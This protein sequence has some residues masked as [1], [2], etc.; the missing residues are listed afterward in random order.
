MSILGIAALIA[1]VVMLC[2]VPQIR[3][4]LPFDYWIS[5]RNQKL[6]DQLITRAESALL[7]GKNA[8]AKAAFE[9]AALLGKENALLMSEAYFGLCRICQRDG[10]LNGAVQ[11]IDKALHYAPK[12]REYKRNFEGLLM[13]EKDRIINKIHRSVLH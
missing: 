11:Q 10:D 2:L 8:D 1:A 9:R 6:A 7:C 13:G 5:M 4:F 12:W 3:K